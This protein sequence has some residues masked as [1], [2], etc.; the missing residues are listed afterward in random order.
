MYNL[1]WNCLTFLRFNVVIVSPTKFSLWQRSA[2][3]SLETPR[4]YIR[5]RKT[6]RVLGKLMKYEIINSFPHLSVSLNNI[7]CTNLLR[8][9]LNILL[10][11]TSS[12][13]LRGNE[14]KASRESTVLRIATLISLSLSHVFIDPTCA[15][16]RVGS[17][18]LLSYCT[19][20]SLIDLQFHYICDHN[21]SS[22]AHS[23][24]HS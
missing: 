21:R 2:H 10:R 16:L 11:A 18:T 14:L 13:R 8:Y 5:L 9:L 17:Y 24:E 22:S 20:L 7:N 4:L 6:R 12:R 1:T 3:L 23:I 19:I 15:S